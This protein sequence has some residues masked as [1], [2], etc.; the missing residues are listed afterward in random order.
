MDQTSAVIVQPLEV[1]PDFDLDDA[2]RVPAVIGDRYTQRKLI[3]APDAPDATEAYCCLAAQLHKARQ[4]RPLTSVMIASAAPGEGKSLTA[5]N[6]ALALSS[7]YG[8]RVVLIDADLRRPS[9]HKLFDTDNTVGLYEYLMGPN[10]P[11]Q[12]VP[13]SVRLSLLPG[14]NTAPDP[15]AALTS[16]RMKDLLSA[17]TRQ[18]DWVIVDAPPLAGFPDGHLLSGLVQGVVLVVHAGRTPLSAVESAV[19]IV[20][21][22][23]ILGVVLNRSTAKPGA[24]YDSYMRRG[25]RG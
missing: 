22:Q 17:Q 9:L 25:Q 8:K 23:S 7:S 24:Y 19:K 13:L 5:A 18:Y 16:D 3:L 14:G 6:L 2:P 20:G 12:P 1:T 15:L 10:V 4:S 11:I 21:R